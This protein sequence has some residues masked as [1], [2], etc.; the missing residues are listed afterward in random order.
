MMSN[1][2]TTPK[3]DFSE[4]FC[5]AGAPPDIEQ[6]TP[7]GGTPAQH[8]KSPKANS[9]TFLDRF[10]TI[11]VW[12]CVPVAL[13][14][15]IYNCW[16]AWPYLNNQNTMGAS[17]AS[18][19]GQSFGFASAILAF[20]SILLI[21]KTIRDQN[22][23]SIK[24]NNIQNQKLFAI[25]KQAMIT[26]ELASLDVFIKANRVLNNSDESELALLNP[27]KDDQRKDYLKMNINKR[28]T[29]ITNSLSEIAYKYNLYPKIFYNLLLPN[30]SDSQPDGKKNVLSKIDAVV[31]KISEYENIPECAVMSR[32]LLNDE[33]FF[34]TENDRL[35]LLKSS[36]CY[37]ANWIN[38]IFNF[39]TNL[40]LD[41]IKNFYDVHRIFPFIENTTFDKWT[42]RTY[43]I[44]NKFFII[45]SLEYFDKDICSLTKK[46]G[47]PYYV[48]N[49]FFHK[50]QI[51]QLALLGDLSKI[52]KK[53]ELKSIKWK[54][55]N[56]NTIL[57]EFQYEQLKD[58][59]YSILVYTN[60][61]NKVCEYQENNK[62]E[63]IKHYGIYF[64]CNEKK[65]DSAKLIDYLK[66]L[67]RYKN[68]DISNPTLGP[69]HM[70]E[71]EKIIKDHYRSDV[72]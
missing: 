64:A 46:P 31:K 70:S 67:K 17:G 36:K 1:T 39:D 40:I 32:N 21:L 49:P 28:N 10:L 42:N 5:R 53:E 60:L 48:S 22:E 15:M 38:A 23:D 62:I 24:A 44:L 11:L 2:K 66:N 59:I 20:F 35:K 16:I 29:Y 65:L 51:A 43:S 9:N 25:N 63:F 19:F 47:S 55:R 26:S 57:S 6:F 12:L 4:T 37:Y 14:S 30:N 54:N 13:S 71:I 27:N 69:K 8:F 33:K 58:E 45:K 68:Y 56:S 18:D 72:L 41:D 7:A 50:K 34:L 52:P 3:P 61:D